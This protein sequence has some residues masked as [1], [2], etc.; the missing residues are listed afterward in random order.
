MVTPTDHGATPPPPHPEDAA[1]LLRAGLEMTAAR[2]G[3]RAVPVL[4]RAVALDPALA[5]GWQALHGHLTTM[6]EL[7]RARRAQARYLR[8]LATDPPLQRAA[9]A[10]CADRLPEA[11]FLLKNHLRKHPDQPLALR[12]LAEAAFCRQRDEDAIRHLTRCLEVDAAM[13]GLRFAR[14]LAY[15]RSGQPVPAQADLETELAERPDDAACRA[16]LAAVLSKTSEI[17]RTV[18]LYEGLAPEYPSQPKLWTSYGHVLKA[19]GRQPDSIAAYRRA[20][21][22]DAGLGEAWWSLANLKTVKFSAA[23]IETMTVQLARPEVTGEDRLH[24]E[25]ALGKAFEDARRYEESFAH[26]DRGNRLR[27]ET[28]H[29][30]PASST[31][32]LRRSQRV[33][34]RGFFAER[35]GLGCLAPDPIF[36]VGL[37]RAGSTLLEQILASH[38]MVEGTMELPDITNIARGIA[39]RRR[40]D[41]DYDY[42]PLLTDVRPEEWRA[43]GE[44]YLETTRVHR[45]L[46]R[47]RFIDKMPNNFTH[48][49]LIHLILPNA[50]IIDAR[51]HPLASCF[52]NFKQHFA[53][54]QLFSYGLE[55]IG[56]FYRD[57][58]ELMAHYD[59]VLPGRVHR[60]FYERM[61]DDTENEVRRLLDH[62]GLPFD[63][64][65]LRFYENDRIV[66]TASSEQVRRPIYREGVDHWRNYEPWLGPLK[67]ALGP[68]LDAYPEVPAFP[69]P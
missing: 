46:G 10:L 5:E 56:D 55:N 63:E 21:G 37:P 34:T 26:Y 44:S 6:G 45:K 40:N 42:L 19:A 11:E 24:F 13:P 43:L 51:R 28:A 52:S 30:D 15:Y 60:V 69:P 66:R 20:I 64:S 32:N 39:D 61:V 47:P 59:A 25:F 50:R 48:L 54:G 14:A 31:V 16:L 41:D 8:A 53:L 2:Q 23:D 33:L 7:D 12:L 36:I 29:Y 67:S 4:E 62:C 27:L 22:L 38:P 57:Y 49:G 18:K 1:A 58:V 9:D 35:A 65:C 17:E 3:E 68:V